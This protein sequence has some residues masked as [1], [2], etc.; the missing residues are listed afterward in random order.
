[1]WDGGDC[2]IN[3]T[4]LEVDF[5]LCN[6]RRRERILSGI[7]PYT[8]LEGLEGLSSSYFGPAHRTAYCE[9]LG[10]YF[11]EEWRRVSLTLGFHP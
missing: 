3:A 10:T 2:W 5:R 9:P 4:M 1:M 8:P 7:T 6:R 11:P